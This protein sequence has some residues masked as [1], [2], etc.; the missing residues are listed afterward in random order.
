MNNIIIQISFK[1]RKLEVATLCLL[2]LITFSCQNTNNEPEVEP[3]YEVHE[4][5]DIYA[6]GVNDPLSKIEWLRE[7]CVNLIDTQYFSEVYIHLHK[8]IDSDEH[9]F[10]ICLSFPNPE[11]LPSPY[12]QYWRDCKG[13]IVF[14]WYGDLVH[15]D[16]SSYYEFIEDKEFIVELFHFVKLKI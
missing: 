15:A 3:E 12:E 8:L 2:F 13:E 14:Y 6:C 16:P 9:L 5:H 11:D 7:Y 10:Q 4:N 1:L